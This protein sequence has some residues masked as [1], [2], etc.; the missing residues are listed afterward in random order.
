MS[1][2]N[3]R[4]RLPSKNSREPCDVVVLGG[5]PAGAAAAIMLARA[6]RLLP[7]WK[8]RTTNN[9]ES[10]RPW[11]L[12]PDWRSP[13]WACGTNSSPQGMRPRPVSFQCGERMR[14]FE[15]HFIFNPLRTGLASRPA[16]L[17][18]DAGRRGWSGRSAALVRRH[19]DV[20]CQ[21]GCRKSA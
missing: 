4:S 8:S 21:D 9:P 1:K 5:G 14:S 10:A 11:P 3:A 18:R 13:A 7:C 12:P 15:N 6:G 17:R 2:T 19:H 16:T 20:V